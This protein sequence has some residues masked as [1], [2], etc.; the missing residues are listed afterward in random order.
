MQHVMDTSGGSVAVEAT[1]PVPGLRLFEAPQDIS[2]LSTY[3]WVLAHHEGHALASFV[4]SAAGEA[5]ARA[6]APLA[7]W[8]RSVMTVATEI[9][10]GGHVKRLNAAIAAHGGQHPNA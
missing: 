10:L 5:A 6:V 8:T 1:E 3:R 9:S 4:S 2:P 7:D